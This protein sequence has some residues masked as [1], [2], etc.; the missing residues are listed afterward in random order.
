MATIDNRLP[1]EGTQIDIEDALRS[2]ATAVGGITHPDA[3]DIVYD[4]TSSGLTA[5]NVQDAIDE[6]K[7]DIPTAL[8]ELSDDSTH[9]LVTDSE[10]AEWNAT[11]PTDTT[12]DEP[13]VLRQGK[14]NQV[15]FSLE[16]ASVAWN[17]LLMTNWIANSSGGNVGCVPNGDGSY[18]FT[19]TA[20]E[21]FFPT[22]YL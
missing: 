14:G 1:T 15:D 20:N 8:S 11:T 16:G 13:Y 18:T 6:V 4:N 21:N 7:G 10:K 17:Q 19:G 9:R 2:I 5:T 12:D 3:E 22:K